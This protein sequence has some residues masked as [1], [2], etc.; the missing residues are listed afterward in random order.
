MKYLLDT[1]IYLWWLN[2]DTQL[3]DSIKNYLSNTNNDIFVSAVSFWE[4]SIKHRLGKLPMKTSFTSLY[5]NLQFTLMPITIKHV[6]EVDTLPNYHKDP[7]DRMLVAQARVEKC[8]I[9][10]ND[11]KIKD[12]EI[13]IAES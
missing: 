3:S 4:I 2:D 5:D 11:P 10:T 7:F 6:L 1:H 8:T 12:Y 13:A 9:I